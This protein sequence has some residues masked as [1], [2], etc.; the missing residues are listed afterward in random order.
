MKFLLSKFYLILTIL[1]ISSCNRNDDFTKVSEH[2]SYFNNG[3]NVVK[4]EKNG[5][6]LFIH[7]PYFVAKDAMRKSNAKLMR[8]V[9]LNYRSSLNGGAAILNAPVAAPEKH[10]KFFTHPLAHLA[11]TKY[12]FHMYRFHPDHDILENECKV[13]LWLEDGS[14]IDFEGIKIRFIEMRGDTD[15]LYY[16]R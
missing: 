1:F 5:K 7:A 14:V 16:R 4:V 8:V 11:D 12:F 2:V 3:M 13:D 15:G 10:K 9:C 6:M